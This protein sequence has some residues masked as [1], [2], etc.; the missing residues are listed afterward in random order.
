MRKRSFVY[1]SRMMTMLKNARSFAFV[2][3]SARADSS[4]TSRR[5]GQ[6]LAAIHM[7]HGNSF[8]LKRHTAV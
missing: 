3:K 7:A 5:F 1:R 8:H 6:P 2:R 4:L